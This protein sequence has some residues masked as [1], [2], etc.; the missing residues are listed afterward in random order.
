MRRPPHAGRVDL[1]TAFAE[2]KGS[3]AVGVAYN[4]RTTDRAFDNAFNSF[5]VALNAYW[6]AT[7]AASYK[8]QPNV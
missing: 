4:G 1:K 5:D 2:D 8:I 3:L 6:L 7:I